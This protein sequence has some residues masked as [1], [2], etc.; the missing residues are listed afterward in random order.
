[1]R[2]F[3]YSAG[4]LGGLFAV[5]AIAILG[6]PAA[7]GS[8]QPLS[9]PAA[10]FKTEEGWIL[11]PDTQPDAVWESGWAI[12]VIMI[13]Q[14]PD[15]LS[16]HGL[17]STAAPRVSRRLEQRNKGLVELLQPHSAVY[18][19]ALRMPSQASSDADWDT[20]RGDL[21]E[22]L[23]IYLS[24]D[25]RGRAI[26]FYAEGE[27][28][29]LLEGL[30]N[31]LQQAGDE[32]AIERVVIL[33]SPSAPARPTAQVNT[34]PNGEVLELDLEPRA[35]SVLRFLAWPNPS[36]F[37][38]VPD[39]TTELANELEAAFSAALKRVQ[40]NAPKTV[41][42]FG[43]IEIVREAPVNRPCEAGLRCRLD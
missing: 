28:G 32:G 14:V 42:P 41:E 39:D 8:G 37:W 4:A 36:Q 38:R 3:I 35:G 33:V 18:M 24:A 12:D 23:A 26:A 16:R 9:P 13:P 27:T 34:A 30:P 5:F 1:M 11:R 19:P 20:A 2:Y 22:A 17:V 6:V 15:T 10:N 21:A 43:A 29:R 25:N 31:L 7:L 40:D